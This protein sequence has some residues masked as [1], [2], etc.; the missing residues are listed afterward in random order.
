MNFISKKI[1]LYI[2]SFLLIIFYLIVFSFIFNNEYSYSYKMYYVDRK[3]MYWQG[4]NGLEI[5]YGEKI[6]FSS[7]KLREEHTSTKGVQYLGKDF[8]FVLVEIQERNY[9]LD[10][11]R[12]KDQATIYYQ[13]KD[14]YLSNNYKVFIMFENIDKTSINLKLNEGDLDEKVENNTVSVLIKDA[15]SINN[16]KVE[17]SNEVR[18]LGLYFEEVE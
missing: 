5:T 1:Y 12:I 17:V 7:N 13:I 15:V 14:E 18:V 8:K 10:Q 9:I 3:T 4:Y 16:L 11:I 6:D 2:I